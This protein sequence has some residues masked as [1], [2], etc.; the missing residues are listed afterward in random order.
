MIFCELYELFFAHD[1]HC[2]NEA[3]I[4][5]LY[6]LHCCYIDLYIYIFVLLHI[7][8]CYVFALI[9]RTNWECSE[10][11]RL[12]RN[13]GCTSILRLVQYFFIFFSRG[14]LSPYS[15][16]D[17]LLNSLC[18]NKKIFHKYCNLLNQ[19]LIQAEHYLKDLNRFFS[20]H[21][22]LLNIQVSFLVFNG[23]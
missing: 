6:I 23:L 11:R 10:R 14:S 17:L 9:Y 16:M 20:Q 21:S 22:Y 2:T 19:Q 3:Y 18:K 7:C 12:H 1:D 4:F 15:I 8:I 5:D 13:V